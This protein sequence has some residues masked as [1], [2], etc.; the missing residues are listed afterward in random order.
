MTEELCTWLYTPASS[1]NKLEKSLHRGADAVIFDLEDAVHADQKANARSALVEFLASRTAREGSRIFVRVNELES[2]W[3]SADLEAVAALEAVEG[4]R[5]PKVE[6]PAQV[7]QVRDIVG[8]S[9]SLQALVETARGLRS[10]NDIV[11][12]P[13]TSSVSIGESDLR[14]EL[15]LE[16]DV[17]LDHVRSDLVIALASAGKSAPCASVYPQIKDLEGLRADCLRMRAMGF[18]G[19]SVLHPMQLEVVSEAFKPQNHEI[20]WAHRVV[21]A[22]RLSAERGDGAV[23]LEDGQFVDKPFVAKANTIL[24]RSAVA[25]IQP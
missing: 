17:L 5:V 10:M 14:A 7:Q 16:G 12:S 23:M 22:D 11:E 19:R 4:I 21:E 15:N 25:T 13:G 6:S 9:K 8:T 2:P 20:E 3:G 1:G 18:Y 24:R